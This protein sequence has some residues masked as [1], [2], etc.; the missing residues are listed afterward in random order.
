MISLTLPYPPSMNTYWRNVAGRTLLSVKGRL[1]KTAVGRA[2]SWSR[3]NK[4]LS[5]R[6]SVH[7]KLY[8]ADKRKR[9]LDNSCKAILDGMQAAGVYLDDSQIDRLLVERCEIEKGGAAVVTVE[10]MA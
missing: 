8:P 2:V 7:I 10:E 3:A 9:D 4:N 5:C 6:L 1:Y